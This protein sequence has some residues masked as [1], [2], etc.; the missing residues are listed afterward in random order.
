[1]DFT[2]R[3]IDIDE[4]VT[5][6]RRFIIPFNNNAGGYIFFIQLFRI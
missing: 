5:Q 4:Q 2:I 6:Y 1:M 3:P